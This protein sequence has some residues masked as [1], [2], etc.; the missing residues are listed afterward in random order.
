ME[1]ERAKATLQLARKTRARIKEIINSVTQAAT[2]ESAG[3]IE[4][5]IR[6]GEHAAVDRL[7]EELQRKI[8]GTVNAEIQ[9]LRGTADLAQPVLDGFLARN[10][11]PPAPEVGG[12]VTTSTLPSDADLSAA[13]GFVFAIDTRLMIFVRA[14]RSYPDGL[15][16]VLRWLDLKGCRGLRYDLKPFSSEGD[17]LS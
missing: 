7:R 1:T 2:E 11:M 10:W 6:A 8:A 14:F 13:R 12:H 5:Q 3:A 4:K 9:K 17:S 15:T 16:G